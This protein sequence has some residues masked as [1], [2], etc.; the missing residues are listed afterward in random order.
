MY[1]LRDIIYIHRKYEKKVDTC[2]IW[3]YIDWDTC[4]EREKSSTKVK[5]QQEIDSSNGQR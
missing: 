3:T 2:L 5:I 1:I 4:Q